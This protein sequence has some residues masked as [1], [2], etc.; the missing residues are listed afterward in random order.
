MLLL[1]VVYPLFVEF[2]ACILPLP[3]QVLIVPHCSA[4]VLEKD[5][6]LVIKCIKGFS[7]SMFEIN[8]T[9]E[10]GLNKGLHLF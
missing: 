9:G 7:A 5:I 3:L 10:L 6:R 8:F 1:S 4:H 2:P